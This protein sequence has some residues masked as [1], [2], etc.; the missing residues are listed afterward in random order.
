MGFS[1]LPALMPADA[2]SLYARNLLHFVNQLLDA[3][4]GE[5]KIDRSDEI[6]A[7]T[8]VCADGMPAGPFARS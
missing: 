2:S 3:K 5:L 1:N 4:T 6:V 8:M 7:G